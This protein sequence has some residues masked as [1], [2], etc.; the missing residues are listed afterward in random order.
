MY[1]CYKLAVIFAYLYIQIFASTVYIQVCLYI[2]MYTCK[3][4]NIQV[5]MY[6]EYIQTCT[7]IYI[8]MPM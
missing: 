5:C 7:Y 1:M 2:Y 8:C 3:L 4:K 6:A